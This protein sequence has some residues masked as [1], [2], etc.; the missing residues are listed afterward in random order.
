MIWS[1]D[2]DDNSLSP[3]LIIRRST[4][5]SKLQDTKL[6]TRKN[7]E[8]DLSDDD[9]MKDSVPKKTKSK[10]VLNENEDT[11]RKSMKD[12]MIK[13]TP[14]VPDISQTL[15]DLIDKSDASAT[16]ENIDKLVEKVKNLKINSSATSRRKNFN[17]ETKL[18]AVDYNKN[19]NRAVELLKNLA[20]NENTDENIDLFTP[21]KVD[22]DQKT[23]HQEKKFFKL[24]LLKQ[25]LENAKLNEMHN[26]R[27][28]RSNV[29][30]TKEKGL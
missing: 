18:T 28:T 10:H 13:V 29:R 20:I 14:L 15:M 11:Q 21:T 5:K 25:N 6:I 17:D 27:T 23:P 12:I 24:G 4:R 8:E 22:K 9:S 3:P 26:T 1:D 19:V 30:K 16:T 2:E 7:L